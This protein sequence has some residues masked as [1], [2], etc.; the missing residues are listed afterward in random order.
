MSTRVATGAA[1]SA[2]PASPYK[3]LA[4]FEDSELDELLFFGRERD[5]TVIAANLVAARLTVLY[6]PTGVGKSSVLRA[7]VARDLRALPEE[8][9]VVVHDAW[10]EDPIGSLTE[11]IATAANV[12][13]AS[14]ADTVEV[15]AALHG[16]VYL[17]FDQLEAYFV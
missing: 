17:L 4:P 1:L 14:L 5:R 12:E 2:R 15:A 8:P 3:G 9:L 11:A 10:A 7:G 13:P 16:D 6:G